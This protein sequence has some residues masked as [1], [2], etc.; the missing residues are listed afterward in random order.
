M[1]DVNVVVTWP[2]GEEA[3]RIIAGADPR[4]R[5]TQVSYREPEERRDLRR[6]GR[7]D[8]LDRYPMSVSQEL[9]DALREA[10]ALYGLDF[11]ND[12]LDL[13]PR[14]R[15]VQMIGVGI[16]HLGGT[17]L[18]ESDVTITSVGG[19]N[20]LNI[21]EFVLG[22][23]LAHVK[24]FKPYFLAQPLKRWAYNYGD[25][26][27]G[28]TVGIVGLGRIGAE[29]ARLS[30][31]FEMRVLAT[32][33]TPMKD[34]PPNVDRLFAAGDLS[35]MLPECDFVVLA[36][37]LT[38]ET[39][40]L[41]GERELRAMKSS[42][43]LINVAR[44]QVVDEAALVRAL[45]E[46]WIAGAGLDVFEQEPLPPDSPLWELPNAIVTPHASAAVEGYAEHAARFVAENLR[47]FVAGEPLMNVV[48]RAKGY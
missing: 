7:L 14:L 41:I 22:L 48:D 12:V 28:K 35:S 47:R 33:R 43:F 3:M 6:K 5:V 26:L 17:G 10:D 42:A 30:K 16:D 18:M 27:T 9:R 23:M 13:A 45:Q 29:T 25:S 1:D 24:R 21:A 39:R 2:A 31:A 8:E 44:G 34:T 36:V 38:P 20:S 11:P 46:G 19:F 37:A 4:V 40:R 15:W 32:R